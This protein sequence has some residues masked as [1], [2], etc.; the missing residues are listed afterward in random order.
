[1]LLRKREA[2]F[3]KDLDMS[4]NYGDYFVRVLMCKE[5]REII[6]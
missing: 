5:K 2:D 4:K 1:M 3:Y 6:S